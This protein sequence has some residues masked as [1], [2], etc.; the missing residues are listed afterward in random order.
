MH[1]SP[2]ATAEFKQI[3]LSE[4]GETLSDDQAEEI[5]LRLLRVFALL[6]EPLASKDKEEESV[7]HW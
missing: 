5:A 2:K 3:Y 4:F 7:I 6:S 1:L